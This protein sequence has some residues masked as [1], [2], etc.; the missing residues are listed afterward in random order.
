[1]K[2]DSRLALCA[3]MVG[4]GH[5]CDVGTD[6]GYLPAYLLSEGKCSRAVCC[7]INPLPLESARETLKKEGVAHMAQTVLSDGLESVDLT[8]V[9][10]I[11]IAGMGG[12]TIGKILSSEKSR[13]PAR[14]ILQPMSRAE[15]LRSFLAR[16]GFEVTEE[17]A[18]VCGGFAYAVMACR[19]TGRA[20]D[21]SP[22]RRITGLLSKGDPAAEE[23]V[24]RQLMRIKSAARGLI[25]SSDISQ[26]KRGE[27]A[28]WVSQKIRADW[29]I[30]I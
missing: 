28:L 17:R 23:Y 27:E 16:E 14:F 30:S 9:T 25:N 10:D 13:C 21:I 15:A 2:L 19:Y 11:V 18:A 6:H 8:E 1:M 4:G 3:E 26:K 7:D 20:Y 22:E 24:R 29:G 12:E 5:I